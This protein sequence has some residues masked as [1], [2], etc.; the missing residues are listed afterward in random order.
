MAQVLK[1]LP[2]SLGDLSSGSQQSHKEPGTG[3][4]SVTL[5]PKRWKHLWCSL[6]TSLTEPETPRLRERPCSRN[7]MANNSGR[8][9]N[10]PLAFSHRCTHIC[11]LIWARTHIH[12][13]HK[14]FGTKWKYKPKPLAE[15][16]SSPLEGP[17]EG[18][19]VATQM[20]LWS[21]AD[22]QQTLPTQSSTPSLNNCWENI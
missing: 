2:Y 21:A 15:S 18:Q 17:R 19:W 16:P 11:V 22:L 1:C 14:S 10:Q 7:K 12:T 9:L 8:N 13:T 6:T 4:M 20:S 3:H 5:V